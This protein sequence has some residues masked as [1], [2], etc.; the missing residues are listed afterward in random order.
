MEV[1]IPTLRLFFL[2]KVLHVVKH[3]VLTVEVKV[4]ARAKY[5]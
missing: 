1:K 2:L 5:G 4:K 3:H